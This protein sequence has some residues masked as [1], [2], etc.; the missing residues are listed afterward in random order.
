MATALSALRVR[1]GLTYPFGAIESG[2]PVELAPGL[3][4]LRI[5]VPGP[6][7]HVNCYLLA[8]DGGTAVVD[9]GMNTADARAAWDALSDLR[10]SRVIGTHFHPDHIGLAGRLCAEHRAPLH[11]TRGE[12]LL[13]RMLIADAQDEVPAEQVAFWRMAGWADEQVAHACE[14]GWA[15]FRRIVAPLSLS[16]VRIADGDRLAV[17]GAEWR[18]VVG[19]GHSP[20]HACLLDERRGL[21]LAGDQVLPRISP[22]V[23]VPISE[24]ESNPLGDWLLSI[25]K[26]R[27]LDPDLLVL[28][29]HGDPFT[30]LHIRLDQMR[31]EHLERLDALAVH[32]AEPRR[33]VDCFAVLFQRPVG[34]DMLGMA[35]GEAL[36]HLRRL[37]RDGRAVAEDR[38]GVRWWVATT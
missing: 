30:G 25:E 26:L 5:A 22:N 16:Y 6:L 17:G 20:E 37:E 28:P 8:D 19:S 36:A 13:A 2:A 9:T 32:L 14:R 3:S 11:M 4:V 34:P 12:W 23:S 35:T 21:L 29:G 27:G 33:A 38:D 18:V 1:N 31:D 15:G 10:V 24:P 7:R